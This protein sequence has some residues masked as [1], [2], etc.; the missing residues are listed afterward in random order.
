MAPAIDNLVVTPD[1]QIIISNMADNALIE[2]DPD[3]GT[4]RTIVS[5]ALAVA[6]DLAATEAGDG[7]WIADVFSYAG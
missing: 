5:S 3:S 2:I 7:A 6:G 1:D 4:T